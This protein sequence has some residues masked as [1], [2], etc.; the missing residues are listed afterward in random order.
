MLLSIII[1]NWN[2]T[3]FLLTCLET[4]YSQT[5]GI[6]FET[7]VV[8]NASAEDCAA[9][10]SVHFPKVR[11][12]KSEKNLG[13]A[14]A[15]NLGFHH[16]RGEYL[17]FLNPDTEILGGAISTLL[18]HLAAL[19][20]AG[21]IGCKLLNSDLTVQTSSI[22]RFPTIGN[23]IFSF[24]FL[25]LKL[26]RLPFWG[27]RPLFSAAGGPQ[28]IEAISG[29]CILVRREAFEKIGGFA[30]EYFMYAEDVDLCYRIRKSGYKLYFTADASIIHHGG[31]ST[32]KAKVKNANILLM[33]EATYRFLKT[34][35][36]DRYARSYKIAFSLAALLR[37]FVLAAFFPIAQCIGKGRRIRWTF[38]KWHTV[39]MWALGIR[40]APGVV[41]SLSP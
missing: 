11:C 33:K 26:P 18:G 30:T 9:A 34:W 16:T 35:R 19:R 10:L 15:N 41:K 36:G 4:V 2:S 22:L 17:L 32:K 24:E 40:R 12:V 31:Q 3:A 37:L 39:L 20:D 21:A 13:F 27:I 1:V 5:G 38:A 25:R 6:D 7:I 28:E 14:G 8:D 29:A 23:Q